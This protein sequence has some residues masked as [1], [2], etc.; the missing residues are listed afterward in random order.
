MSYDVKCYELAA[1]F[2]DDTDTQ[3]INTTENRGKLAQEIQ[4]TIENFIESATEP[5]PREQDPKHTS[6]RPD[7]PSWLR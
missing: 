3:A 1:E 2:L 7:N 6:G 4:T 5:E